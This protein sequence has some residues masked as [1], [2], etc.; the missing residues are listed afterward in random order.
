VTDRLI[1]LDSSALIKLIFE[2]PETSSLQEF[3]GAHPAAATS[4]VTQIEVLRTVG[5]VGDDM[6][7]REARGV[8]ERIHVIRLDDSVLEIATTVVPPTLRSL[9]AIQLAS[10]LSIRLQLAGMV[11]YDRKLARAAETA[12][13]TVFAPA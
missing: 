10:A 2:E 1:Y 8:L 9:D 11:V 5:R 6:V 3:F 4:S 7:T 13:L 12:G